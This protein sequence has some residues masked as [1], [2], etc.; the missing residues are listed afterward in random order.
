MDY[1]KVKLS[2]DILETWNERIEYLKHENEDM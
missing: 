1:H 2:D